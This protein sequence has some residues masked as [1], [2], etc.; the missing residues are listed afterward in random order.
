MDPVLICSTAIVASTTVV[1]TAAVRV[2]RSALRG[3]AS[4]HRAAILHAVA[5]VIRALR[6]RS[7]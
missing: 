6:R 1:A 3:T 4:E 2:V 5:E 7:P